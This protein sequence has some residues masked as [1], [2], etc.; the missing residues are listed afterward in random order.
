MIVMMMCDI[1]VVV[2][3]KAN[4]EIIETTIILYFS[5][6]VVPLVEL[7]LCRMQKPMICALN[8]D[9]ELTFLLF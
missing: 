9:Y 1:V 4:I 3:L 2:F 7:I 6:L 5:S 8:V